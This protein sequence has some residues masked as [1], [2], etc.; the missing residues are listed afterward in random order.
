MSTKALVPIEEYLRM[1]FE[2]P[3]PEIWMAS[4]SSGTPPALHTAMRN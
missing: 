2:G 3:D 4:L 1:S